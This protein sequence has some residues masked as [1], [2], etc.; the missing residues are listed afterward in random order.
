MRFR[1]ALLVALFGFGAGIALLA[2]RPF[3]EYPAIEYN[4][5]PLPSDWNTKT[6]WVRARLRYPDIY[7]YPRYDYPFRKLFLQD[8]GLEYACHPGSECIDFPGY[9]TMDYP[10]S[11]RHLLAGVQRLTRINTR[12]TEQVVDLDGTDDVYNWPMMYAVEVGHWL[13]SEDVAKQLGEFLMRGGFLMVD[14]FHGNV[15]YANFVKGIQSALPGREIVDIPD[16][17]PIFHTIYDLDER[18]QVPGAQFFVTGKEYEAG[19]DRDIR[20][21]PDFTA[22]KTPHWR[23]IYDDKGRLIVVICHNMDLGDA[24]EVSDEARYPERWSSLAYR[25][26]MN[27]FVYDLTH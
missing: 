26:A 13:L 8:K 2:Q 11:D 22:G 25:I 19:M 6:D 17:D 1:H 12:L 21:E 14:D 27:Y 15:E 23:G 16:S 7:G 20:G 3:K 10:R 18:F 5:F 24:W 4:N 9:W